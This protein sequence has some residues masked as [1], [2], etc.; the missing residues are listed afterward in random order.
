MDEADAPG[1]PGDGQGRLV[2]IIGLAGAGYSTALNT[3]QDKGYLAVD[4]LPMALLSQ[5]V[6]LEVEAAGKKVAVSV[7]GRT[8]GFDASAL[9]GLMADLRDRLADRVGMVYLSASREELFRRF[10]TTRRHHPLSV[11]GTAEGLTEALELDWQRME[12]LGPIAD[13]SIDTTAT[14]PAEFRQALLAAV[15]EEAAQPIPALVESFSY[16]KGVPADADLVLDMRFLENPHWTPGL[17]EKTGLDGEVQAFIRRD[18]AFKDGMAHLKGFLELTLPRFSAE[19]RPQITIATGCTGGRH[20]SVFAAL[21]LAAMLEGMGHPVKLRH[22]DIEA[23][24]LT[25]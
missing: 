18:P 10:N 21:E 8:S 9:E 1:G 25:K 6:S 16:R 17:A 3:L 24:Q 2:L 5:L 12:P 22:R 19:G 13:A 7:D 11:D 15:G 20:R 4:N 23:R 14:T